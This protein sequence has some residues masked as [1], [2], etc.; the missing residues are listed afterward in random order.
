MPR[1][2]TVSDEDLLR[3][4]RTAFLRDGI[5]AST[6]TIAQEA[7]I[8][9][10]VIFQRFGTK[11]DLFFAAMVPPAAELDTLFDIVAGRGS[12][13]ENVERVGVRL[14]DYFMEVMPVFIPL[15]SHPSFDLTTFQQRHALPAMQVGQRLTEYLAAEARHGRVRQGS[16]QAAATLL[17]SHLHTLALMAS[18]GGHS[19][20][21]T[22]QGVKEAV[23][24]L[25]AGLRPEAR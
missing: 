9:E 15:V 12:V 17:I 16:P 22:R 14:L 7:G 20:A 11:N 23:E 2:R 21:E 18:I 1:R 24:V 10:A 25:W 8:S 3:V 6:R 4:A 19:P 13:V 5:N